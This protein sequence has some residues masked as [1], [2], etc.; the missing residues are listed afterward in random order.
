MYVI[1]ECIIQY[2]KVRSQFIQGKNKRSEPWFVKLSFNIEFRYTKMG[3]CY[4]NIVGYRS[5]L[6]YKLII[7]IISDGV[8]IDTITNLQIHDEVLNCLFILTKYYQ[9]IWFSYPL[10]YSSFISYKPYY[11]SF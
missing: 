3:K 8:Y 2:V 7:F 6:T 5:Y 9:L 1:N 10:T 4:V 11:T